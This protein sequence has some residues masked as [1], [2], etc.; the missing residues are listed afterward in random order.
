MVGSTNTRVAVLQGVVFG[1][2]ETG[3][4]IGDVLASRMRLTDINIYFSIPTGR[5]P[6]A[7]SIGTR[8]TPA[9]RRSRYRPRRP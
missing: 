8:H 3:Q 9:P 6:T 1:V 5:W 2:F 7:L 4:M